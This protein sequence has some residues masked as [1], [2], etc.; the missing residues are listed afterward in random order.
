MCLRDEADR[1]DVF[2]AILYLASILSPVSCNPVYNGFL[3][4]INSSEITTTKKM[5]GLKLICYFMKYFENWKAFQI[6][7]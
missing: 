2:A 7:Q 5:N 1:F 4:Y 6:H 3:R